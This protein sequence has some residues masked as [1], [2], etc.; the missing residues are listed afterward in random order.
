MSLLQLTGTRSYGPQSPSACAGSSAIH[1][2][3]NWLPM[4]CGGLS[5]GMTWVTDLTV[6]TLVQPAHGPPVFPQSVQL[7]PQVPRHLVPY[8]YT[9][10]S[11][12]HLF[13]PHQYPFIHPSIHSALSVYLSTYLATYLSIYLFIHLTIHQSAYLSV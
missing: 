12:I 10:A 3:Q 6:P 7:S 1:T 13:Q 2:G 9:S 8:T 5:R 11:S 4:F